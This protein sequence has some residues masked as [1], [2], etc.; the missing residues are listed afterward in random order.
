MLDAFLV[1]G[2]IAVGVGVVVRCLA[3]VTG[4]GLL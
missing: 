1:G 2:C 3:L 4:G